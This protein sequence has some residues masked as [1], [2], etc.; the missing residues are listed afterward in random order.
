[1]F[2]TCLRST[3]AGGGRKAE[4]GEERL[5]GVAPASAVM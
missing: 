4:V 5:W 1:M 2:L 3:K